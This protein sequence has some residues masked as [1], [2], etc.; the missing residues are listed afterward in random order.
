MDFDNAYN[1]YYREL[2]VFAFQLTNCKQLSEDLV[3]EAFLKFMREWKRGTAFINI[4]AWLY[5]VVLNQFSTGV[6]ILKRRTVLTES[7]RN[8][9]I[10]ADDI[11]EQYT[12]KEIDNIVFEA[13]SQLKEKDRALLMLYRRGLPYSEI[14]EILDINPASVGTTLA[15]AIEKLK[16]NLKRSHHE[17]FE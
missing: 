3:Q 16:N 7:V 12:A 14:A 8:S 2:Y 6:K 10:P 11:H 1:S 17:L 15:R 5:K 4:R 9:E 13:L